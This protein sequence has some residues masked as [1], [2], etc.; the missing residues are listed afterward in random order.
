MTESISGYLG[1]ACAKDISPLL[2]NLASGKFL[3]HGQKAATFFN[4]NI[5]GPVSSTVANIV[6]F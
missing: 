5:I 2:L 3:G 6:A 4:Q 1:I